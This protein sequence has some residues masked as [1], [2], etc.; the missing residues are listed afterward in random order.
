MLTHTRAEMKSA[1]KSVLEGKWGTVIGALL[2]TVLVPGAVL[3]IALGL[4]GLMGGLCI[5]YG[6]VGSGIIIWILFYILEFAFIFFIYGPLVISYQFF[7]LRLARGLKVT[8]TMPYQCFSGENY[9]RLTLAFF[10]QS[11]FTFLWALLFYVPGIIKAL[12]YSMMG[13]IMMD[14]PEMNWQSALNESK[15]MMAGHKADLFVLLLSF[16]PWMLLVSVTC[17]IAALYVYPYMYTTIAN[18][19]RSLKEENIVVAKEI[20]NQFTAQA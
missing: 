9:G 6:A 1:A 10:M 2:L 14:H 5:G 18:F 16:I 11:L 3:G 8:A 20:P 7:N 19:Y 4:M 13:F 17:G 15:Q 12:S